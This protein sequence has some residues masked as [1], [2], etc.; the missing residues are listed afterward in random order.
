MKFSWTKY[1]LQ[2]SIIQLYLFQIYAFIHSSN[3]SDIKLNNGK[4]KYQIVVS[5]DN[6][7]WVTFMFL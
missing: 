2:L 7:R 4:M 5:M 3:M 1:G 6:T